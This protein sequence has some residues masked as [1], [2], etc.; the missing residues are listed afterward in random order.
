M[1]QSQQLPNVF[2]RRQELRLGLDSPKKRKQYALKLYMELQEL[3][4]ARALV[5]FEELKKNHPELYT[6]RRK[7]AKAE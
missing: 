1:V 4:R 6:D 3:T 2:N 7:T 5:A